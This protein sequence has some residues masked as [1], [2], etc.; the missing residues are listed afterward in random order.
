LKPARTKSRAGSGTKEPASTRSLN[1]KSKRCRN[2]T[3]GPATN[4]P[5]S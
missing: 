1:S 5:R 4:G 2:R 3:T